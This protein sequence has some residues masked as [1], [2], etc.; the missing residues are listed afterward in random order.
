M[1]E[2]FGRLII[3]AIL[4]LAMTAFFSTDKIVSGNQHDGPSHIQAEGDGDGDGDG[5]GDG[6]N[7]G[8]PPS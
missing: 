5:E 2:K 6:E 1:W 4:T 3:M 7:G 8:L